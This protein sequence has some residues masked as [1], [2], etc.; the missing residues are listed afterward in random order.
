MPNQVEKVIDF[1]LRARRLN[2]DRDFSV[3]LGVE[4]WLFQQRVGIR[5]GYNNRAVTVGA[6]YRYGGNDLLQ[7]DYAFIYPINTIV[8]TLGS[9]RIGLSARF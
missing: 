4:Q 2:G 1:V 7:L 9:H 8:D 5:A 3:R 6:S